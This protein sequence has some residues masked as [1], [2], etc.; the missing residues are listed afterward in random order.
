METYLKEGFKHLT[1]NLDSQNLSYFLFVSIG[2]SAKN[3]LF[4]C[5][6]APLLLHMLLWTAL[7]K[8]GSDLFL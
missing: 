8:T 7:E 1:A 6:V 3:I 4:H 2:I 5:S